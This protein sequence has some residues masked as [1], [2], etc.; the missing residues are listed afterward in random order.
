MKEF[1]KANKRPVIS[2]AISLSL[3]ILTIL[4]FFIIDIGNIQLSFSALEFPYLAF[5]VSVISIFFSVIS[6]MVR[7]AKYRM[8]LLKPIYAVLLHFFL[9][10][11]D[12]VLWLLVLDSIHE[13]GDP[14]KFGL[15]CAQYVK[16][17]FGNTM[18]FRVFP[19]DSNISS[20]YQAWV[21]IPMT[22]LLVSFFLV[23]HPFYQTYHTNKR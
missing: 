10:A 7:Y 23:A 13:I 9:I 17:T 21:I 4:T 19:P 12:A 14:E 6:L 8:E 15:E 5:F 11:A 16:Q 1:Y 20:I 3:F 22:I 2:L 18:F